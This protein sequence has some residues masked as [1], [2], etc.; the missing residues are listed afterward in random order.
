MREAS[1]A[2]SSVTEGERTLVRSLLRRE[3]SKNGAA[4][5]A[6]TVV[7]F[8]WIAFVSVRLLQNGDRSAAT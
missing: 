2:A 8:L 3:L 7:A 5:R 1:F 6:G 4:T